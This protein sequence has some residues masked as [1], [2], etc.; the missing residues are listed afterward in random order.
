MILASE[1]LD[2]NGELWQ[3]RLEHIGRRDVEAALSQPAGS[4]GRQK[5]L[6]LVSPAAEDYL[7]EMAQSAHRLTVRRFGRTVRL[8][9]PLYLSNYCTNRCRYCGFNAGHG[10]ERTRLT[11]DEAVEE[12]DIIA[13]EGFR[14]ILLVSSEDPRF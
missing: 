13:S 7:E 11:I 9:A 4:Y 3:Q 8:Y 14:D 12:A 1:Q 2:G 5:L 6:A 10:F